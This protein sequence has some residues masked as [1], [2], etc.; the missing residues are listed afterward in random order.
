MR[1]PFQTNFMFDHS[2]NT[3]NNRVIIPFRFPT[4]SGSAST[5]GTAATMVSAVHVITMVDAVA[6]PPGTTTVLIGAGVNCLGVTTYARSVPALWNGDM[7]SGRTRSLRW[8]CRG[9]PND[10]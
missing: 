7:G 8:R 10:R 3:M 4:E 6:L 5:I 2:Q 9:G 1:C